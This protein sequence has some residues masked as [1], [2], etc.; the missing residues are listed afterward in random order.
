MS[1]I[2]NNLNEIVNI[3]IDISSPASSDDSHG[4][5]LV[6]VGEPGTAGKEKIT[7]V[8]AISQASDLLE[9]GYADTE[10]AYVAATVAYSQN[11]CPTTLYFAVRKKN[12][13]VYEKMSEVLNRAN[14]VGGWYGVALS[15][16]F[17]TKEE[18]EDTIKW[19]ESNNKLFGFTY[20]EDVE[21]PV[22]TTNYFRSYAFYA[23][24]VPDVEKQPEENKYAALALMA[25]C[26]GYASGSETWALKTLAAISPS[27]L[28]TTKKKKLEEANVT[29]FTTYAG[30]NITNAKGGRVLANEWI[31]TIR[32]RDW[33]E[34]DMQLRV[35]NLLTAN[36]KLPF[37]DGGITSID[38]VME[39]TL[40]DGQDVGG[41]APTEYDDDGNEIPGYTTSVP[42]SA[43]LTDSQKASRILPG[44]KFSARL[45]GAIQ[46]VNIN[47]N[48]KY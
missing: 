24:D 47:G 36:P 1:N 16:E 28:T 15:A 32:F 21:L 48:L 42:K 33:V 23:G 30:K 18:L 25:K 35:F 11:P 14:D 29:Y 38:G 3:N 8:I 43:K 45:A 31:D 34:S 9:Y 46:I 17:G 20:T 37:T 44:C 41:I 27:K 19:T 10:Q 5:I 2:N 39:A 7:D 22:T 4:N 6:V 13:D 12:G 26:F 40:K